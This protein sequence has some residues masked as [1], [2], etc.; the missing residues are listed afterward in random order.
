MPFKSLRGF[1][2]IPK[3]NVSREVITCIIELEQEVFSW[4][5]TFDAWDERKHPA[6]IQFLGDISSHCRELHLPGGITLTVI[7]MEL[8]RLSN[9]LAS[10]KVSSRVEALKKALNAEPVEGAQHASASRSGCS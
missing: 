8:D 10:P 1:S 9:K 7:M 6:I 4:M 5:E 2:N 3:Q